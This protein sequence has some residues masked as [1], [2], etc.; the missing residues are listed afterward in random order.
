MN[1]IPGNL[2][3]YQRE[4]ESEPSFLDDE[5]NMKDFSEQ[6]IIGEGKKDV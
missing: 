6:D 3:N 1:L 4:N 2:E 5:F